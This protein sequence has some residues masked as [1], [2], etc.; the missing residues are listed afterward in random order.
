[1]HLRFFLWAS[2]DLGVRRSKVASSFCRSGYIEVSGKTQA[3]AFLAGPLDCPDGGSRPGCAF[4]TV[5]LEEEFQCKLHQPRLFGLS[6]LAE[7]RTVGDDAIRVIEL[8]MVEEIEEFRS[9]VDMLGFRD[10][11]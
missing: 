9:E 11:E 8:C 7:L 4:L 5:L 10:G 3:G 6:N 1:M 2:A